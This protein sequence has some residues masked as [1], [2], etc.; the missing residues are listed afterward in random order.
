MVET[1]ASESLAARLGMGSPALPALNL[2]SHLAV[3]PGI[4]DLRHSWPH[5]GKEQ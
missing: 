4:S 1:G 5:P 2:N 3:W